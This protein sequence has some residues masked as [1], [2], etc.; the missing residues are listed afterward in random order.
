[1]LR[2]RRRVDTIAILFLVVLSLENA[3]AQGR[4]AAFAALDKEV[5]LNVQEA[6]LTTITRTL[7]KQVG[8]E[9]KLDK[10]VPNKRLALHFEK[11]TLR[12]AL[13]KVMERARL[14]WPQFTYITW[15][16][17]IRIVP[18]K[19]FKPG[20]PAHQDPIVTLDVKDGDLYFAMK[21]LFGQMKS[22]FALLPEFRGTLVNARL[23][24]PLRAAIR[25][26]IEASDLPLKCVW[27]HDVFSVVPVMD[28]QAANKVG[29]VEI[30]VPT[31]GEKKPK[32]AW[33]LVWVEEFNRQGR[34]N[35]KDWN[36]ENGFVR[37]EEFQW[38]QPDN[39]QCENG[40]LIIE[41]RRERKSN[42]NYKPGSK[43]WRENR[44]FAEYSSASL[45]TQGKHQW[46]YGRFEMRGRID[47]RLG[48]WPAFWTLG[49]EGEW[50]GN[51]EIDI[52]EF[53]RGKLLANA[54]WGTNKRWVAA[55]DSTAKPMEAFSDPDWSQKFH[56]WRM[57]WDEN[58]IRLY[59]DD[60]LLNEIDLS[61][62]VNQD[63]SG[64]NPFRQPHY[65]LLNLAIGGMN[66]GDPSKTEFPARFEI[67]YVRV[68]QAK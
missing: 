15:G 31:E 55:W 13:S 32:N 1:M 2:M 60:L 33:K 65:V 57:D 45:T 28:E 24:Q 5:S 35:P 68:Y 23:K 39:A 50:P 38:Y 18:V 66:G 34:P 43:E 63:K 9:I 6:D 41:A 67:D 61:K 37:N 53:Y 11:E 4:G 12:D 26:L 47:T 29:V 51:G 17:V 52:M 58:F 30:K 3:C 62:T 44:E 46:K 56:V 10:T 59:V 22:D 42:P 25:T 21:M 49:V 36:F 27:E 14:E 20:L 7:A 40:M 54:A 19:E 64:K 48:M 16:K 8:V